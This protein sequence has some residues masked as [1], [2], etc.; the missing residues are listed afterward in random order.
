MITVGLRLD[1]IITNETEMEYSDLGEI[2]LSPGFCEGF[3]SP[4]MNTT[5]AHLLFFLANMA[6]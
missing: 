5:I 4:A 6:L 2:R 1:N 3:Q